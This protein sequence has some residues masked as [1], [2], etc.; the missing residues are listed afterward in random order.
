MNIILAI[1]DDRSITESL[2]AALPDTDLLLVESSTQGALR[3]LIS[4]QA[5]V[6]LL[7]DAPRLGM[8]A[9]RVL[10]TQVPAHTRSGSPIPII[11]LSSR[12]DQAALA[13]Y[14]A[15]GAQRCLV[16][17]FQCETL[18][19]LIRELNPPKRSTP[20]AMPT[21]LPDTDQGA[22]SIRQHQ[23]A[24]RWM[25]RNLTHIDD[26]SQLAQTLVDALVDTFD[27]SRAVV[28][29]QT[30]GS[31]R[32]T[33]S[34]GLA[35]GIAHALQLTFS[36][37][38]MRQ[39]EVETR[40][41]DKNEPGLA[42][43]SAKDMHTLGARLAL[44]LLSSG[45]VCGA[46]LIGE[47]GLGTD[48]SRDEKELL[49]LMTRSTSTLLEKSAQY[50]DVAR[51]QNRLDAVLANIT[52]G[53]V[54]VMPDKTIS[55]MNESA[56]R[57]LK[58]RAHDVLGRSVQK[59]GSAFANIVLGAIEDGKP[60][61]RQTIQDLSIKSTL[62]L[63]VTPLGTEGAVIIFSV[64][65]ESSGE[66]DNAGYDPIWEFLSSRIAQEIKNPM[67]AISTFAQLLPKKYNTKDFREEFAQVVQQEIDRING[68]VD[69]LFE[70]ANHPRL[71]LKNYSLREN[72]TRVLDRLKEQL[73]AHAIKVETDCDESLV[74][75]TDADLFTRAL[76]NVVQNSI[77][78]M[79]EGGTLTF[80]G[81]KDNGSCILTI[82]DTGVGIREQ[83]AARIFL[84]FY[85]TKE[86][87]LGL[88]LTLAEKIM[89]QLHG[90]VE[91]LEEGPSGGAFAFRIPAEVVK[92]SGA[93]S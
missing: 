58:I 14:T 32:V 11:V 16:K 91:L 57:I 60:R 20:D 59:L 27:V 6:I 89:Q 75:N 18:L 26:V 63:S 53:V 66:V 10:H 9:L 4:V 64:L 88:G 12:S 42:D 46:V 31:V 71:E 22:S 35:A 47:K 28:L 92:T 82:S 73:E 76:E 38:L 25:S 34:Y 19:D 17:P 8:D 51:Q 86:K 2:H 84:P 52:A 29:L 44:P 36:N 70:F 13:A 55:M 43:G 30:N 15:A 56:E 37:G 72:V 5:D 81:K 78:A 68:V 77:D 24:L 40:L 45:Q 54:T 62:G 48:F 23:M 79:P 21:A 3:Q 69:T 39:L 74:V 1:T 50:Q 90:G 85:S 7:D 41:L 83:D 87:G 65:P 33:A 67:V 80:F 49:M 93:S 61:L